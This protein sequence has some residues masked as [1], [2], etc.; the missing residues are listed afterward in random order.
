[1]D[2]GQDRPICAAEGST[3]TN[4]TA[5]PLPVAASISADSSHHDLKIVNFSR[6]GEKVG[7]R[8]PQSP[9]PDSLDHGVG[10]V[11]KALPDGSFLELITTGETSPELKFLHWSSSGFDITDRLH[12]G[13]KVFVPP[14]WSPTLLHAV[15][16]PTDVRRS[17]RARVLFNRVSEILRTFINLPEEMHVPIVVYVLATWFP[18]SLAVAPLLWITGPPTS[19]KTTLLRLLHCLCR[20]PILVTDLTPAALY[21]LPALLKPTLLIDE[22]ELGNSAADQHL[23]RLIRAGS[24]RGVHVPRQ[25]DV[26]DPFCPKAV[27][28]RTWPDD[29]AVASRA[30]FIAM[31]PTRRSLPAFDPQLIGDEVDALQAELLDFRLQNFHLVRSPQ[32]RPLPI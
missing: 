20:R 4:Q 23:I 17:G 2:S 30:V 24:T 11:F 15:R 21:S 6:D 3:E 22:C 25:G 27:A 26:F 7:T 32:L 9:P 10:T 18:E 19:V 5:E 28:S 1:M 8:Y 12:F 16:M 29:A 14:R 13:G 31:L